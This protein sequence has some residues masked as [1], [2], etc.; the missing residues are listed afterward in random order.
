MPT[1]LILSLCAG[2]MSSD[3]CISNTCSSSSSSSSGSRRRGNLYKHH[4]LWKSISLNSSWVTV[5]IFLCVC[6]CVCKRPWHYLS[7]QL[8]DNTHSVAFYNAFDSRFPSQGGDVWG[9]VV[10]VRGAHMRPEKGYAT[11]CEHVCTSACISGAPRKASSGSALRIDL[12]GVGVQ[13]VSL[14]LG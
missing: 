9:V 11:T 1:V 7:H 5:Q 6:V 13:R 8:E 3:S 12:E 2:K 4:L 14:S 10:A